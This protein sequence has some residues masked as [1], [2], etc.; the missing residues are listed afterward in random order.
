MINSFYLLTILAKKQLLHV[1]LDPKYTP[2]DSNDYIWYQNLFATHS[3]ATSFDLWN[4]FIFLVQPFYTNSDWPLQEPDFMFEKTK[5][6]RTSNSHGLLYF[7]EIL[8]MCYPYRCL[9]S[10]SLVCFVPLNKNEKSSFSE[11]VDSKPFLTDSEKN[12]FPQTLSKALIRGKCKIQ[13]ILIASAWVGTPRSPHFL[14]KRPGFYCNK[15]IAS[16]VLNSSI[17]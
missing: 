13:R 15:T 6:S 16:Y 14:N 2:S 10:S 7:F 17:Y 12:P 11:H 1:W 9:Q 8:H 5:S 3:S 4:H